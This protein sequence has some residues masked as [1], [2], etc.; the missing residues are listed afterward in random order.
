MIGMLRRMLR[1]LTVSAVSQVAMVSIVLPGG[2]PAPCPSVLVVSVDS[3]RADG[4]HPGSAGLAIPEFLRRRGRHF[5]NAIAE[6][7]HTIPSMMAFMTGYYAWE[8]RVLAE[9]MRTAPAGPML[10]ERLKRLGYATAAIISNPRLEPEAFHF[11]DGFDVFDDHMTG[12]ELNRGAGTR[13]AQET[14][15]A[16]LASLSALA[17]GDAPWFMWV[18]YLEPH[19]PFLP[20]TDFVRLPRDPGEPLPVSES[21]YPPQGF[22]PRYQFIGLCRG[23]NDYLTRYQGSARYVLS[24]VDR[25]LNESLG[26]GWLQHCIIIFTSDHGELLGEQGYWFQHG[27]R[28]DPGVVRVPLVI[29]KSIDDV[30]SHEARVVSNLDVLPTLL[31]MLGLSSDEGLR[32]EDVYRAAAQR[33]SPILTESAFLPERLELGVVM[34]GSLFVQS[35]VNGSRCFGLSAGRWRRVRARG[36]LLGQAT[37]VL[38]EYA[39]LMGKALEKGEQLPPEKLER[40][41]VLR[42]LGY[43]GGP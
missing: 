18:H 4:G 21:D 8:S 20:P 33:R 41:K 39:D 27:T 14:T 12:R 1:G 19:G 40:L 25:F 13:K 22:L 17:T 15:D 9:G 42:S 2:P 37:K 43:L 16:A 24:E 23:R 32:G 35:S 38:R 10:A 11:R 28:I 3:L 34:N 6:G 29:A 36:P 26:R 5:E 30:E 7:N 31:A